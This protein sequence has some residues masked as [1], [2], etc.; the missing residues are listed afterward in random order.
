MFGLWLGPCIEHYLDR[1]TK[2]HL[3]NS[4]SMPDYG[5]KRQPAPG[6]GA[7]RE[8]CHPPRNQK[9]RPPAEAGDLPYRFT[10]SVCAT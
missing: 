5:R 6:A 1:D 7:G 8:Q 9:G 3:N 4:S 10:S 2:K